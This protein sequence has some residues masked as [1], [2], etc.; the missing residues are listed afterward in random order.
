MIQKTKQLSETEKRMQSLKTQ[1][2]GKEGT[3]SLDLPSKNV[4]SSY[5]APVMAHNLKADLTKIA[6]LATLCFGAQLMLYILLN[7]GLI[8]F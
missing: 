5:T 2:Y 6:I 3:L 7:S 1:L 4:P 8:K